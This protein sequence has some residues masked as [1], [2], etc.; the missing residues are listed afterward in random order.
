MISNYKSHEAARDVAIHCERGKIALLIIDFDVLLGGSEDEEYAD[1]E[2]FFQLVK[3]W[4]ALQK[5]IGIVSVRCP[6]ADIVSEMTIL[7]GNG[8]KIFTEDNVFFGESYMSLLNDLKNSILSQADIPELKE[9]SSIFFFA[10][11]A[12]DAGKQGAAELI[13]AGV[14]VCGTSTHLTKEFWMHWI[15]DP[16]MWPNH[17]DETK[18]PIASPLKKHTTDFSAEIKTFQFSGRA[19]FEKVRQQWTG[20]QD[21]AVVKTSVVPSHGDLDDDDQID[22]LIE[23]VSSGS[24]FHEPVPLRAMVQVLNE[25]W[26]DN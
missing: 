12:T 20:V 15:D 19:N 2:T 9:N 4:S 10:N 13:T 8:Q 21:D 5:K 11:T 26:R 16:K 25:I 24:D 14:A 17:R 22:H 7:F 3:A 18:D 23:C 6:V 1:F